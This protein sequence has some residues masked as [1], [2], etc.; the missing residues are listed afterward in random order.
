M[1][2]TGSQ[3]FA[4]LTEPVSLDPRVRPDSS[5][6]RA[7]HRGPHRAPGLQRRMVSDRELTDVVE[8]DSG[9]HPQLSRIDQL[10]D[11]AS[12]CERRC[13][14]EHGRTTSHVRALHR[15]AADRGYR[16]PLR[17]RMAGLHVTPDLNR[18]MGE[19]RELF[20]IENSTEVPVEGATFMK[21]GELVE[22]QPRVAMGARGG[23]IIE[24]SSRSPA[25]SISTGA[26]SPAM[27]RARLPSPRDAGPA[28][29][30]AVGR[31]REAPR[32]ARAV[33]R[34]HDPDPDR[35]RLAYVDTTAQLGHYLELCQLEKADTDFFRG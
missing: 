28:R 32:R 31:G 25:R 11:T 14:R 16:R 35:A 3:P 6:L 18:G 10:A 5:H 13:R 27:R 8:L 15:S 20:G 30:R 22:W 24:L 4:P 21:G 26:S 23:M 1:S 17:E 2:R 29:R 7:L 34:V 9:H 33:I 19:L 12:A